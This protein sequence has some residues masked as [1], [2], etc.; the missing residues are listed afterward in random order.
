[1]RPTLSQMREKGVLHYRGKQ[2]RYIRFTCGRVERKWLKKEC[3]VQLNQPYPKIENLS[4][5]VLDLNDGK[6]KA[7]DMPQYKTDEMAESVQA[8]LF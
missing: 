8:S 5:L 2:Y 1:M 4:W 6:W 3:L 7:S